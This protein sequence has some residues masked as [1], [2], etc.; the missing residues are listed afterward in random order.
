MST[1]PM[2]DSSGM[3]A[4][5]PWRDRNPRGPMRPLWRRLEVRS[6][7]LEGSQPPPAVLESEQWSEF[8]HYPWRDRNYGLA[9]AGIT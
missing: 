3:F 2:R 9:A 8:A 6:L 7:P 1:S 4:H 5:Y